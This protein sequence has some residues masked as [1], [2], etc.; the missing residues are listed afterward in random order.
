MARIDEEVIV[1]LSTSCTKDQA[2]MKLLG[3]S[4]GVFFP[5]TNYTTYGVYSVDE[6]SETNHQ[7]LDL[8][9]RLQ[10]TLEAARLLYI[11]ALPEADYNE[12]YDFEANMAPEMLEDL[13]RKKDA[14]EEIREV[15]ERAHNYALD[16][17]DELEKGDRS[18]LRIDTETTQRTGAV[19]ITLR[20]LEKWQK[21][22]Y[23]PKPKF[24]SKPDH[25]FELEPMPERLP[26]PVYVPEPIPEPTFEAVPETPKLQSLVDGDFDL[27]AQLSKSVPENA[28]RVGESDASLYITLAFAVEAIAEKLGPPYGG[29]G[30]APVIK[31]IAE[32][33]AGKYQSQ[34]GTPL[35]R[36]QGIEMIRKRLTLAMKLKPNLPKPP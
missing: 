36:G 5:K 8:R 23:A 19:H 21:E 24:E 20:S 6:S 26:E 34:D 27:M 28:K 14:V 25:Q 1:D 30:E 7:T 9:G 18:R 12:P 17:E 32:L 31:Q 4:K 10:E 33:I 35:I 16:I 15:I 11:N 3:W 13:I 2:V 29:K 22:F